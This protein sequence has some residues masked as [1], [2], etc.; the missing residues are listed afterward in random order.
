MKKEKILEYQISGICDN[1]KEYGTIFYDYLY[2][3]YWCK[4]C[5]KV[6]DYDFSKNG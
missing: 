2:Q 3:K 1:C 4:N 5:L 6:R